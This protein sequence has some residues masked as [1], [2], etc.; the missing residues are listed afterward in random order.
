M[1]Q[2]NKDAAVYFLFRDNISTDPICMRMSRS[3]RCFVLSLSSVLPTHSLRGI[4]NWASLQSITSM[5]WTDS[6]TGGRKRPSWKQTHREKKE[7]NGTRSNIRRESGG[8]AR[9]KVTQWR[10]NL[11][12]SQVLKGP[13]LSAAWQANRNT[14]ANRQDFTECSELQVNLSGSHRGTDERRG[15]GKQ[16]AAELSTNTHINF[17]HTQSALSGAHVYR[18]PA[19]RLTDWGA[20]EWST[21]YI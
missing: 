8:T 10:A 16:V 14:N 12:C 15:T 5:N 1:S 4:N 6:L 3:K 9:R 21:W 7:K 17:S 18:L 11:E 19:N 13:R 20:T 2:V